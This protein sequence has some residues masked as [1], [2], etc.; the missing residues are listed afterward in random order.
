MPLATL[1]PL[2]PLVPLLPLKLAPLL[3]PWLLLLPLLPLLGDAGGPPAPALFAKP[4]FSPPFPSPTL[5]VLELSGVK[6]DNF[7]FGEDGE[8]DTTGPL[9]RLP[10]AEIP[11][12]SSLYMRNLPEM[13]DGDHETPSVQRLMPEISSTNTNMLPE[14]IRYRL[15]TSYGL[16][17]MCFRRPSTVACSTSRA[18]FSSSM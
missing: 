1:V 3:L 17:G 4:L 14:T 15:S 7:N 18:S 2:V 16:L 13:R 6:H 10:G 11:L 12:S 9:F 8:E 5:P